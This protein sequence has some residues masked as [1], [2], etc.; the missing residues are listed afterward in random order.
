MR[1]LPAPMIVILSCVSLFGQKV[2]GCP[3][4]TVCFHDLK[5][6]KFL[7]LT[8]ALALS[9]I[10]DVAAT[11]HCVKLGTCQEANPMMPHSRAGMYAVKSAFAVTTTFSSLGLRKSDKKLARK[12]WWVPQAVWIGANL[13]GF[14]TG[15]RYRRRRGVT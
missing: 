15:W 1:M 6:A 5:N 2:P 13:Y 14:R 8:G 10:A 12:L 7:V 9:S 3:I 4:G 11:Q